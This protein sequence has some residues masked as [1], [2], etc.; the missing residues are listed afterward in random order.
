MFCR[1]DLSKLSSNLLQRPVMA[2][3]TAV[4]NAF[5]YH[6][7]RLFPHDL[8]PLHRNSVFLLHNPYFNRYVI[9]LRFSSLRRYLWQGSACGR[10]LYSQGLEKLF[11]KYVW[12]KVVYFWKFHPLKL[13][14]LLL[15]I[16]YPSTRKFYSLSS[17]FRVWRY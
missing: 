17:I 7:P 12:G 4:V 16:F 10:N 9:S 1:L 13:E 11:E 6:R 15:F 8:S 2:S 14:K 5:R 3:S